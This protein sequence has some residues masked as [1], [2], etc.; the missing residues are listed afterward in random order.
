MVGQV[1]EYH[2]HSIDHPPRSVGGTVGTKVW[3][4]PCFR[5]LVEFRRRKGGPTARDPSERLRTR[6]HPCRIERPP[7]LLSTAPLSRGGTHHDQGDRDHVDVSRRV[8]RRRA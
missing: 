6:L 8:R 5:E 1:D 4:G 2:D 3:F 7:P